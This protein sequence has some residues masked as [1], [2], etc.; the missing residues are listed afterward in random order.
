MGLKDLLGSSVG[1]SGSGNTLG[2]LLGTIFSPTSALGGLFSSQV[3]GQGF[4]EIP[5]SAAQKL[6]RTFNVNLLATPPELPTQQIAP[7]TETEQAGFAA[8]D[9]LVKG[10]S[11]A[12]DY[13][14]NVAA[15]PVD[16]TKMPEYA[17][18]LERIRAEGTD[19]MNALARRHQLQGAATSS[20]A[21]K[22]M[23]REWQTVQDNMIGAL[24]PAAERAIARR[25][26]SAAM[27][28]DL[29]RGQVE[30][31][32]TFNLQRQL[33]QLGL[34]AKT[35]QRM[36]E[37]LFPY[38]YQFPVAQSLL[39]QPA[40]LYEAGIASPSPALQMA[41]IANTVMKGIAAMGRG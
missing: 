17:A 27:V 31:S 20:P 25:D 15:T 40:Y 2:N 36:Q 28:E 35:Q 16:V 1:Y 13:F 3:S 21:G 10:G 41:T 12:V 9:Q 23:A 22:A 7:T 14:K 37:I 8:L 19:A 33:E 11:G 6:A 5:L 29:L 34:D 4:K 32:Q 38:Q 24:A 18:V 30:A 39:G 26:S